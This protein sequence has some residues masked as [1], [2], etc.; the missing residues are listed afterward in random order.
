MK[1]DITAI[2]LAS[3]LVVLLILVALPSQL[4]NSAVDRL[5]QRRPRLQLRGWP[6][7][8]AGV[9]AVRDDHIKRL[10]PGGNFWW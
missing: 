1:T 3:A 7:S 2:V 6:I 9:I 5:G 4:L 10:R 8:V